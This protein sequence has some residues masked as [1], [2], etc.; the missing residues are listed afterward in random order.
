VPD[1]FVS[2]V[3]LLRASRPAPQP[4]RSGEAATLEPAPGVRDDRDDGAAAESAARRLRAKLAMP[5]GFGRAFDADG[6]PLDDGPPIAISTGEAVVPQP[7]ERI[8]LDTPL[9]TGVRAIDGLLTLAR[10]ARVGI[11]GAPGTG[12]SS[13][14][15]AIARGTA[16]DALV[17]ALIGE[18][19]REAEAW[20][21]RADAR[22]AVVCAT[23]DRAAGE[24]ARAC[25]A[26]F[27][28]A[29]AL[30]ARGLH[31]LLIVDSLARYATA[32]REIALAR[33][34]ATGRGGF[35]P[36]VFARLAR[37]LEGAGA[38]AEGSVTAIAS[39]LDDGDERDPV[40]DAARSLLDGH[41]ALSL[42]RARAGR[43]PAIDV[44]ASASRT[45]ACA[46]G[47]N[48]RASAGRVREALA[49][50]ARTADARALGIAAVEPAGHRF[51][52]A[53]PAIER[54]LSG[55]PHPEPPRR[56]LG[57]LAEIADTLG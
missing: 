56:T 54:L 45:M 9:W 32:L 18:R 42:E 33:G 10:G 25:E 16:A 50:L 46:A 38:T 5:C 6:R 35:P 21:R 51:L 39:V 30:R 23:G 48:H 41:L 19:G 29:A 11:F 37:T 36:S 1:G 57:L 27:A 26:A 4:D 43:F 31:V 53:E 55:G 40:S 20:I 52:Q 22:T 17:V 7:L 13:L 12:K 44:L 47:P 15:E 24:R 2:L 14:L 28:H 8:A 49:W 34:E 3:D